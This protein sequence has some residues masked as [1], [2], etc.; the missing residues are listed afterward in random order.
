MRVVVVRVHCGERCNHAVEKCNWPPWRH[1][2]LRNDTNSHHKYST[3]GAVLQEGV[4][5]NAVSLKDSSGAISAA[6][7]HALSGALSWLLIS[8]A[9]FVQP[10]SPLFFTLLQPSSTTPPQF[11]RLTS[12]NGPAPQPQPCWT[13]LPQTSLCETSRPLHH[14]LLHNGTMSSAEMIG[15]YARAGENFT[16]EKI[17]ALLE[18]A[19]RA[20]SLPTV[21]LWTDDVATMLRNTAT[22]GFA[23]E[24]VD[25]GVIP[26]LVVAMTLY[27]DNA[28]VIERACIVLLFVATGGAARRSI[29]VAG[30]LRPL[31][32]A[33]MRHADNAEV[34]EPVCSLLHRLACNTHTATDAILAGG[35]APLASVLT[36]HADSDE[37]S[38]LV[39]E[40][41]AALHSLIGMERNYHAAVSFVVDGGIASLVAALFHHASDGAAKGIACEVLLNL[42]SYNPEYRLTIARAGGIP[43][44]MAALACHAED[45]DEVEIVLIALWRFGVDADEALA[46]LPKAGCFPKILWASGA[47][48]PEIEAATAASYKDSAWRRRFSAVRWF[49]HIQAYAFMVTHDEV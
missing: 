5:I 45:E 2:C 26:L 16:P 4:I 24:L 29:A 47:Y 18:A 36:M 17:V 3:Y 19:L 48:C 32:A 6:H 15:T 1:T 27:P 37:L 41:I 28:G 12:T 34:M 46:Q 43:A 40:V 31:V 25:A 23:A 44:L 7:L 22:S 13:E 42:I 33:L 35:V 20:D 38:V 39:Y 14:P 30:G 11:L 10:P 9:Q 21:N 8:R 49:M